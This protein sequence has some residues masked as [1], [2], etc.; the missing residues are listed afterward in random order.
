[1]VAATNKIP[2][3]KTVP[4]KPQQSV[5]AKTK[6]KKVKVVRDSFSMPQ[7][8]YALISELKKKM[9]ESGLKVKKSEL[10]RAGLRLLDKSNAA[11]LK[12][13]LSALQKTSSKAG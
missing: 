5:K 3:K 10:L 4:A 7:D 11:Q 12:R 1:M 13:T 2:A 6:E 9:V 8:D